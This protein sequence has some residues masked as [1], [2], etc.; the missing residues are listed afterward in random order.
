MFK[1]NSTILFQEDSITDGNRGRTEDLNHI[2]GHGY[3]YL[4]AA[5][6]GLDEPEK[7]YKFINRGISGNG[8]V[9]LQSRW[10]EDVLNLNP[11]IL[12]MLIGV[13]DILNEID[14]NNGVPVSVYEKV[15][16]LLLEETLEYNPNM[17]FILCEP[18]ILPVGRVLKNLEKWN[19]EILKRQE[20]AKKLSVEFNTTFVSLQDEFNKAC[21]RAKPDYWIWDGIHP[22]TVGHEIIARKWIK[23]VSI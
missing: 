21:M 13:N 22:T 14:L 8:I 12:S 19:E 2:L 11:D 4:I 6:L 18:F 1:K 20:V 23:E 3:A 16:R 9:E 17:K 7:S 15:Y 10:K 5:R